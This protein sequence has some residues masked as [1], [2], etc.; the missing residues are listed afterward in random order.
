MLP[1]KQKIHM[2]ERTGAR[3]RLI[4]KEQDNIDFACGRQYTGVEKYI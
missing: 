2:K 4:Y 1:C 3:R